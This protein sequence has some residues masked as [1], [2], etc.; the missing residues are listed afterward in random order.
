MSEKLSLHP[1]GT[2]DEKVMPKSDRLS[3]DGTWITTGNVTYDYIF[4][5]PLS[6]SKF[7]KYKYYLCRDE[8]WSFFTIRRVSQRD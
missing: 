8:D 5:I 4:E 1:N 3:T 7:Q 2:H 6:D